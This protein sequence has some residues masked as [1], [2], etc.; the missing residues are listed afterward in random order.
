MTDLENKRR[1][2]IS[3]KCLA[4]KGNFREIDNL[5][6]Y[7]EDYRAAIGGSYNFGHC[8]STYEDSV[9]SL[10][11]EIEEECNLSN[12]TQADCQ[13]CWQKALNMPEKLRRV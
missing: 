12:F 1:L 11:G 9:F 6:R 4:Y 8:P 13:K 2:K 5:V 3:E 7:E 10:C